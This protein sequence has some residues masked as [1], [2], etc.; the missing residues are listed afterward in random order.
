M[1]DLNFSPPFQ[2][3]LS[4][5]FLLPFFSTLLRSTSS[6]DKSYNGNR[7]ESSRSLRKR[8]SLSNLGLDL[9]GILENSEDSNDQLNIYDDDD[10]EVSDRSRGSSLALSENEVSVCMCVC[11]YVC[12]CVCVYVCMCV[13]VCMCLYVCMCVCV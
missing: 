9:K 10:D 5:L 7:R 13:C 1:S 3:L 12:M 2:L 6:T 8:V 11:V 4:L